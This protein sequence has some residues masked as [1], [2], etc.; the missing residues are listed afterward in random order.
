[1]KLNDVHLA[2]P[3]VVY[4]LYKGEN[5]AH[6]GKNEIFSLQIHTLSLPFQ[7]VNNF[8]LL[9]I[10]ILRRIQSGVLNHQVD[11]APRLLQLQL[12]MHRM[13]KSEVHVMK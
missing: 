1:M 9:L 4:D 6:T 12:Q 7:V 10:E 8:A 5:G 2:G 3:V 11:S 13:P